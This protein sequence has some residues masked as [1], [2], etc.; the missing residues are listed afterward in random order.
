MREFIK[1]EYEIMI[2][3]SN[4]LILS[5]I[6]LFIGGLFLVYLAVLDETLFNFILDNTH[7]DQITVTIATIIAAAVPMFFAVGFIKKTALRRWQ[8]IYYY[9]KL[10]LG[11]F[12]WVFSI[13]LI[14]V[15]SYIIVIEEGIHQ[16]NIPILAGCILFSIYLVV[17]SFKIRQKQFP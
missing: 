16:F 13:I 1:G 9:E 5:D 7:Q 14:N 17:H 12:F 10:I 3:R 8:T 4:R 2:N 6:P 15:F 11:D